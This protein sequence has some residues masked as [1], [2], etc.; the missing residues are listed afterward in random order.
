MRCGRARTDSPNRKCSRQ[1]RGTYPPGVL[2]VL[3]AVRGGWWV[4]AVAGVVAGGRGGGGRRRALGIRVSRGCRG[5]PVLEDSAAAVGEGVRQHPRP[6]GAGRAVGGGRRAAAG[7]GGKLAGGV[8]WV[9]TPMLTVTASG[10][11][12]AWHVAGG[13]APHVFAALPARDRCSGICMALAIPAGLYFDRFHNTD[14][15]WL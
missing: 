7:G 6:G 14:R 5:P 9:P 12:I 8:G 15:T 10:Q 3:G 4:G 13:C 11:A 2:D 1:R